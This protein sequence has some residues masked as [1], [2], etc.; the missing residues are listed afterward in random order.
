MYKVEGKL[1][2]LRVAHCE[3]AQHGSVLLRRRRPGGVRR[4]RPA[5]GGRVGPAV[6]NGAGAQLAPRVFLLRAL[7]AAHGRE[8]RHRARRPRPLPR[9]LLPPQ[10]RPALLRLHRVHPRSGVHPCLQRS[11]CVTFGLLGSLT[12]LPRCLA[13]LHDV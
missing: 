7:P 4:L 6:H 2:F 11:I 10:I 1:T 13:L 8:L 12:H 5:G 9:L 3:S